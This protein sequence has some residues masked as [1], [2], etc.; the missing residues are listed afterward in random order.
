MIGLWREAALVK[1]EREWL[2]VGVKQVRCVMI[3]LWSETALVKWEREP[4][5][6]SVTDNADNT[7]R[8]TSQH[9]TDITL[10]PHNRWHSEHAK[11]D[12]NHIKTTVQR[13]H[14]FY[15]WSGC[16]AKKQCQLNSDSYLKHNTV[17]VLHAKPITTLTIATD[18]TP[19]LQWSPVYYSNV[20]VL[21]QV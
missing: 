12:R 6:V 14:T 13:Q 9:V 1:W 15:L 16:T 11:P 19:I 4:S 20:L 17:S 2:L 18:S 7:D 3:G 5:H 8:Y 21:H 10:R